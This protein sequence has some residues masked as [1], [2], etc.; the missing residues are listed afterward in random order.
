MVMHLQTYARCLRQSDPAAEAT[1]NGIMIDRAILAM[2]S[3][4]AVA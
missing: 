4:M 1:D 2:S 3:I